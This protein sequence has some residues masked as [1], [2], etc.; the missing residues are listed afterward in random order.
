MDVPSSLRWHLVERI[1]LA[2]P[3]AG[4]AEETAREFH[5]LVPA[6]GFEERVATEHLLGLGERAVDDRDF[7]VRAPMDPNA[8][9]TKAH[10]FGCDQPPR[11]HAFLDELAHV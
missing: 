3:L 8:L 5:D 4:N 9:R 10:A 7:A 11:L 1:N 2:R 6:P